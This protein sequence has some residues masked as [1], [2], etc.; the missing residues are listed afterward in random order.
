MP[1]ICPSKTILINPQLLTSKE[2]QVSI[3]ANKKKGDIPG[4]V[5]EANTFKCRT[6]KLDISIDPESWA[7]ARKDLRDSISQGK[8]S[9]AVE[10]A[11]DRLVKL[12]EATTTQT[13]NLIAQDTITKVR[14]KNIELP[15]FFR[16]VFEAAA[17][18]V[19]KTSASPDSK[20][21]SKK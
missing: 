16:A 10:F 7:A 18:A 8:L 2:L 19:P 4:K 15:P 12:S 1:R 6:A 21:G 17:K 9:I 5:V 11:L 20:L 13:Q 3:T 14:V